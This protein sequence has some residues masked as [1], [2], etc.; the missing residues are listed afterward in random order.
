MERELN[1]QEKVRRQKMEDLRAK[2][3]DPFGQ[4]FERTANSKSIRDEF[5]EASK[6]ELEAKNVEVKIAGRIM[7]KRRM[8]KMCFM[9]VLDKDG[10]IQLVINKADVGEEAYELVKA[11]DIG[12][13]IGLKGIVYR[14]NPNDNNPKGE[15]SVYVKEYTHLSKALRPLPEKFHGLTDVEERYRRRYVDLIMNDESRRIAF[16]RPQIIRAIQHNLDSQGLVEVETP[17]LNPI[18]GGANARPFTTHHNALNKEFYLRIATEL[19]LKRLIVGGMEGVYE[20]GRLFRNEGMD[21]KHNPEF[22]TVEAY[23][24][25]SDLEGMMKLC[26]N[27]FEEVSTKVLG[28]TELQTGDHTISLKAPFKRVNM[29]DAVNEKT[30]KDFRNIT[31]EEAEAVCKEL[32]IEL[33]KHEMDLGHIINKLFEE[34]CEEDMVGPVF[35]YG[36]PLE[37]SP[38]AKKDPNDP[39]FT[40]RFELYINGTEYANAFTELNDPIDQYERFEN[41]LKAKELGDDEATEM[42]IDYVEALEY[43]MPPTGGIGIGIDRF[44]MLLAGTDSIREV[45]LF[46]TMKPREGEKNTV[47]KVEN[48]NEVIDFSKVEIEPLFEDM[49]DFDTFSK[50]DFRAVKV[51]ACESVPKSKKLLKFTLNDGTGTPRTIL[52]GIHEY[53]EPEELVGK[54]CIAIVNLPPRAMMG[55]DSCGMLI[56]AVHHEE[57]QEKLHLL[58][59]DPHIPA[60]AKLY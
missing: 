39:R 17:V 49:V 14:T 19:Y 36:H 11:S 50:S 35:V 5:G 30:G 2:G 43:G 45:L 8:G 24:A 41:Q 20:I 34:L 42:D 25:Y 53:Y 16:L 7:S 22:T 54:T 18:L 38:L 48:T 60:G 1:D 12:D 51:L 33:E 9:H 10:Q 40:L 55:I 27:L 28:T 59:V 47:R 21:L 15:L 32:H 26:E 56:S 44:V 37:I 23:V 13:I 29:T 52:S 57:G 4:A 6:E 31:L 58:Q 46:P 3:I